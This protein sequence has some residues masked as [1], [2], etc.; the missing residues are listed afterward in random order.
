MFGGLLGGKLSGKIARS[1][2]GNGYSQ[3]TGHG[4]NYAVPQ[5]AYAP[6]SFQR[7][8]PAAGKHHQH[9]YQI[10]MGIYY[11][12]GTSSRCWPFYRLEYDRR[13]TSPR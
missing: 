4:Y 7:A 10:C 6:N 11:V 9:I 13:Y 3:G 2:S 1:I 5:P 8:P 12:S